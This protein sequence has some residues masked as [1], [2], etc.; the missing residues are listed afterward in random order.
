MLAIGR[1]LARLASN[2]GGQSML[3]LPDDLPPSAVAELLRGANEEIVADPKFA[4]FVH[5]QRQD[6]GSIEP[7]VDFRELA[8]YRQGSHMAVAFASDNRGMSTYA[9]VYPLLLSSGFPLTDSVFGGT[10]VADLGDFASSLANVLEKSVGTHG[11]TSGEFRDAV[12][13]I[14]EFLASA[15]EAAGSGQSSIASDWWVHIQDW[16]NA[17]AIPVHLGEPSGIPRLYGCAGLPAPNSGTVLDIKPRHYVEILAARWSAP[18]AVAEELARLQGFDD[19]RGGAE[20]L[21]RLDWD[22]SHSV[23][24]LRSDSP[25]A[26]VALAPG[27]DRER[28]VV[29]WSKIPEECFDSFI[30]AREKLAILHAGADLPKSWKNASAVLV[31]SPAEASA[32][33]G[34][35]LEL[36]DIE[37][38]IP[39]KPDAN[40]TRAQEVAAGIASSVRIYGS[41]GCQA[42]FR[43]DSSALS[44]DGLHLRG[45][46][47]LAPSRKAP[48]LA[49]IMADARGAA[50]PFLVDRCSGAFI[51]IRPSE[52]GLWAKPQGRAPKATH[53]GPII[54][55]TAYSE[56][57]QVEL[58]APGAYEF[59]IVWGSESG[60]GGDSLEVDKSSTRQPWPGL[61]DHGIMTTRDVIEAFEVKCLGK[62]Q[63]IFRVELAS[64]E[65]RPLSPIVA[66]AHGTL[67]DIARTLGDDTLGYFEGVMGNCLADLGQGHFLGCI[68]AST[69]RMQESLSSQTEGVSFS[70][71]LLNHQAELSPGTPGPDLLA[72]PAYAALCDAYKALDIPDIIAARETEERTAGLTISRILLD[73]IPKQ[74]IEALLDAYRALLAQTA[75]LSKA[76]DRFWARNPFSVAIFQE[77]SGLRHAEAV[78][79]SPLHPIRLAW[80][81]TLQVGLREAFDDGANPAASLALLDGT[82]FPAFCVVDDA[83]G[84][85]VPLMPVPVDAQPESL[86]LGWHASVAIHRNR[87]IMPEWV[88][89]LRFPIDGLSALSPSS[90]GAAIDDFL[91]VS[92]HVQALKIELAASAVARRSLSID[93]GVLGKIRDLALASPGLDGVAGVRVLDSTN[94]LGQIPKFSAVEDAVPL[95]RPGFNAEWTRV[96]PDEVRGSHITLLEGSAAQLSM[97]QVS[98]PHTG[99]LPSLPLHRTPRRSRQQGFATLNFALADPS[100]EGGMLARSLAAYE[101]DEHDNTYALRVIPNLAGISGKPNWLVAGDFGIDPHSLYEQTTRQAD[102]NYILWDWRPVTTVKPNGKADGRAQPYF[103]LASVPRALNQAIHERLRLLHDA[104][105]PSEIAKRARLLVGT[106]ARRAVGLNT[107]LAIG[108]HQA[109]GA[110]GFFFALRSLETWIAATPANEMRLVIPV[111]AVDPFLRA[112]VTTT[113]DGSRRRADLLAAR[114]WVDGK[115]RIRVTLAPIEIKHYGL[116]MRGESESSFPLAG[117]V[118]LNEHAEQLESYQRQLQ[119]L[120]EVYRDSGGSQL[121]LLGQRIAAVLDAGMQLGSLDIQRG[122]N[123]LSAVASGRASVELG[124]GLLLWYQARATGIDGANAYSDEAIGP[125]GTPRIDVCVDPVAFDACFWGDRDGKAHA[126]LR[127]SLDN[128]IGTTFSAET[129]EFPATRGAASDAPVPVVSSGKNPAAPPVTSGSTSEEA[130]KA[131]PTAVDGEVARAPIAPVGAAPDSTASVSTASRKK[132]SVPELEKRYSAVVAALSEFHVKV[133]RPR[134]KVPYQE[135]PAFVEYAV[136]PAYGVSVNR[137]ESQLDNLKLRLRLPADAVIGCSTDLGNVVLTVPKRDEERYFVDAVELWSRWGRP[138]TG[139]SIPVGENISGEIVTINLASSNSPHLLIAGVTGSGKSEAL[140]TILHGAAHFYDA[141]ELRLRLIDPKQ[142]ELNTLA[143]LPHVDGTIGFTAD[144]AVA[145][146]EDSAIEM[147]ERY[148]MFRA[149]GQGIRGIDEYKAKVGPMARWII[150]LDEYADLTN[151]DSTR[152]QIEKSLQRLSQKARAAGIHV[153]V[154]TQKPVVQV[155]NTVVRGNLPGKIALR[156]NTQAESRVILDEGGAEQLLGKGDALVKIGNGVTRIQFARYCI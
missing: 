68:L 44:S 28:R 146:L 94:R 60:I 143:G 7:R 152:K 120:C 29:G 108:H 97:T 12:G 118:R 56:P 119:E 50:S 139:F 3:E 63:P 9:S 127:E 132:F 32:G 86:Y 121:S 106:L 66:S 11:L 17:L 24:V 128:A 46:L 2:S 113:G 40:R 5:D 33:N 4:M 147:D 27:V 85:P 49:W 45:K 131:P 154:S 62:A 133:E 79:L 137:I 52:A 77:G 47:A 83:F 122:G 130:S 144:E 1:A 58:S 25:V 30:E 10:G 141:S 13:S 38:V 109:T 99:W 148:E 51:V 76:A 136:S 107:L 22:H 8:M 81:W 43:A 142:T 82:N 111:D 35:G 95:A 138:E 67:P 149:A 41:R 61:G 37:L 73:T 92:P 20:M 105:D 101:I 96:S 126:V 89:G 71:D 150:V 53:R 140:L 54:W 110:I 34:G 39:F 103:V 151:D 31:A 18:T 153:I 112:S 135:G 102:G 15:Y 26:R 65:K 156:V 100:A 129:T 69:S 98:G 123:F 91:R 84:T 72:L 155:V 42:T 6:V 93:E 117:E 145:L 70:P 75:N 55:S 125:N 74:S 134:G 115:Q 90:V 114:L 78:L 124:K 36:S 104:L 14:L 88:G 19:A 87:P 48:N 59:A 57:M 64:N 80:A 16:S 116:G 21:A 23:S